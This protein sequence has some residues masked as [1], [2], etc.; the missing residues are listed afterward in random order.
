M[1]F[2]FTQVLKRDPGD[3][4][5]FVRAKHPKPVP[6]VLTRN[7]IDSL[8]NILYGIYYLMAGLLYGR[9]RTD[10]MFKAEN[11]RCRF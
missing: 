1:V 6:V 11:Q 3:F 5:D 8:F 9:L 7:E 4:D 2:L 10:G